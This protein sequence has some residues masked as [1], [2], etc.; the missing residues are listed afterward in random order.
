MF[1]AV[2]SRMRITHHIDVWS[3]KT[4]E[5]SIRKEHL[6]LSKKVLQFNDHLGGWRHEKVEPRDEHNAKVNTFMPRPLLRTTAGDA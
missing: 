2:R 6:N 1:S 5:F 3:V 4:D